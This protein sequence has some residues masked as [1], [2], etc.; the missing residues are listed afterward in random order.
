M[1]DSPMTSHPNT[2]PL[3]LLWAPRV[4]RALECLWILT[5]FLVP[6]TFVSPG[7]MANGFDVPKVT[8]YRSLIGL[9][10]AL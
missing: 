6:L 4:S 2:P 1:N 8:L 10:C 9:M 3:E 5:V 7:V